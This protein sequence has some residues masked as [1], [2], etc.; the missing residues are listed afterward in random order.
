MQGTDE[1]DENARRTKDSKETIVDN[2]ESRDE[3]Q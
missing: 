3:E 1:T 2:N